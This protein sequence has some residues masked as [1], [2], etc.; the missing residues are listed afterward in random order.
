M[1]KIIVIIGGGL[2]GILTAYLLKQKNYSVTI[3]E[4][5]SRLGGRIL[6]KKT[7]GTSTELG[8]TWLWK[9]NTQL[10]KLCKELNIKLFPQYMNGDAMFEAIDSK[11]PQRFTLPKNQEI[12]YRISGGTIEIINRLIANLNTNEIKLTEKVKYINY[13]NNCY[14]VKTNT[15]TY[16]ADIVISTIPPQLLSKSILFSPKLPEDIITIANKTHT[17]MKDAIKFSVGYITPFWRDQKLS[18][19]GFSNIGPLT[20]VYDHSSY[21]DCSYALAG[22]ISTEFTNEDKEV[23]QIKVIDQLVKL[24][25]KEALQ[26]KFYE[27]KLWSNDINISLPSSDYVSPHENNGHFIYQK[28]IFNNN[29][30]I[31]GTETSKE[32]GGYMEGAVY[33]AIEIVNQ[34]QK[35]QV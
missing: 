31:G 7:L 12:S 4:A 32:Y 28:P 33:R 30:Y 17:W 11:N 26:I 18:G 15:N 24:F 1:K 27:E 14:S 2:S 20:E 5:N 6:T 16:E 35:A 19:A 21:N 10:I 8:A 9:Y 13:N 25:G 34:I 23:R 29:F 22:F 3:L